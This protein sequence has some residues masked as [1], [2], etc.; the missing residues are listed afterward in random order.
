MPNGPNCSRFS[1][2]SVTHKRQKARPTPIRPAHR[3]IQQRNDSSVKGV[4]LAVGDVRAQPARPVRRAARRAAFSA[5]RADRTEYELWADRRAPMTI[6]PSM[7]II[8]RPQCAARTRSPPDL[9]ESRFGSTKS[10][11]KRRQPSMHSVYL[12][13]SLFGEDAASITKSV[14]E[15]RP[16]CITYLECP[17]NGDPRQAWRVGLSTASRAAGHREVRQGVS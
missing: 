3:I 8:G 9:V 2:L 10:T 4:Y 1:R 17:R 6:Y 14:R 11:P 7:T 16:R 12:A 5:A 15:Q 13:G